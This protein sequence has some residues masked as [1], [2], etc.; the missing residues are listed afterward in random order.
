MAE[1]L[2]EI[3][4]IVNSLF[5]FTTFTG[6][7]KI[8]RSHFVKKYDSKLDEYYYAEVEAGFSKNHRMDDEGSRAG[9]G[10]TFPFRTSPDG[11]NAGLY[12]ENFEKFLNPKNEYQLQKPMRESKDFNIH[13]PNYGPNGK[14]F[15]ENQKVGVHFVADMLP[16]VSFSFYT[17]FFSILYWNYAR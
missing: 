14:P 16:K 1:I 3:A 11:F 2:I 8:K 15:F 7:D 13:S 10:G 5:D 9:V 12:M 6:I 4:G 17:D